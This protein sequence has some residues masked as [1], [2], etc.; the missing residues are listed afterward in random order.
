MIS[1]R[2]AAAIASATASSTSSIPHSSPARGASVSAIVPIPAV[3]VVHALPALQR[4]VLDDDLVQQL[5]HLG[6]R[7]EE[8]LGGDPQVELAEALGQLGLAP[9]QLGLA[10]R[11]RLREAA[12]AR[13]QHAGEALAERLAQ[14]LRQRA[15]LE[16][17]VGRDD[18]DLQLAGAP[19]F[20][21]DEVAQARAPVRIGAH[22]PALDRPVRRRFASLGSA[23]A[24]LARS[25]AV[26]PWARHQP[27]AT[28]RARLPRSEASRQSSI[29][30]TALPPAGA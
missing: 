12:R 26:S 17:A 13:P 5:G 24:T 10:A 11:G 20:A 1:L 7:L 30:T 19:A 18:A 14:R 28:S 25:H 2:R 27:S 9:H 21:H 23:S 8:R 3:E 22:R 16:L 29:A 15:R 4:R 6:V